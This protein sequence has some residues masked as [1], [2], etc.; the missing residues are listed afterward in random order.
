MQSLK[1]LLSARAQL[2]DT[3]A[4]LQRAILE[5]IEDDNTGANEIELKEYEDS[6]KA[7]GIA[8]ENDSASDSDNVYLKQLSEIRDGD[9]SRLMDDI[10]ACERSQA[11]RTEVYKEYEKTDGVDA[12]RSDL[13]KHL[14]GNIVIK[15]HRIRYQ[16]EQFDRFVASL[17][18][19]ELKNTQMS[20][21]EFS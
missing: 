18:F 10:E 7:Y 17:N 14:A 20:L 11:E 8:A 9:L 4:S 2:M 12:F 13:L 3:K 1:S 19:M 5:R 6:A 16:K 15:E 21:R